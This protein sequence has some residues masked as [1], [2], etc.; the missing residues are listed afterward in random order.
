MPALAVALECFAGKPC[1]GLG[2][3]HNFD[4]GSCNQKVQVAEAVFTV[5]AKDEHGNL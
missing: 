3:W 1:L 2:E 4:S 5:A